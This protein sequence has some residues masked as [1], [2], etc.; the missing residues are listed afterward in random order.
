[1]HEY[2]RLTR[3]L[4]DKGYDALRYPAYVKIP[5]GYDYMTDPLDNPYG[6]FEYR[7]DYIRKAS[8]LTGCG[9]YA[10][11]ET[12]FHD[13]GFMGIDWRFENNNPVILC[14]YYK[15]DCMQNHALLRQT[16][17]TKGL[18]FCVCRRTDVYVYERSLEF[19]R[20]KSDTEKRYLYQEF[21]E[22]HNDR[23][24]PVHMTYDEKRKAWN[25]RYDPIKCA[26]GCTKSFCP[27]RGKTISEKRG[28]V[29]YDLMVRTR[30]KDDTFFDGQPVISLT[31][32]KRFLPK[33]A[34]I[35]ICREI[36]KM[37]GEHIKKK[38]W[39][40]RYSMWHIYDPDLQIE[41]QNVR[42]E[43]R[44]NRDLMKDLE[45][46]KNGI[47]VVHES[48]RVEGE[49]E[50]RRARKEQRK[51]KQVTTMEK[52]LVQYGFN[53]MDANDQ[54]LAKKLFSQEELQMLEHEHLNTPTQMTL[55]DSQ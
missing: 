33:P 45:D 4:V 35:D 27:V 48:D 43:V 8:F 9:L 6:G 1:M 42:A 46:I 36:V 15:Y 50:K 39:W 21:I 16:G 18:C 19:V 34:S 41:V 13:L 37:G 53:M 17:E 47:D 54:R 55:F 12:C 28:N 7:E 25:F 23:V 30:R 44:E 52:K 2:N 24:C 5:S 40:N 22:K 49:K 31:K 51:K 14:P 38:E 11:G 29:F 26:S 3:V 20:N 32:G 10:M